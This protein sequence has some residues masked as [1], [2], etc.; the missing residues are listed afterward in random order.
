MSGTHGNFYHST[1]L[2]VALF[3]SWARRDGACERRK[4][5]WGMVVSTRS[6]SDGVELCASSILDGA[7][8]YH[9]TTPF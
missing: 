8:G 6:D 4:R 1:L 7:D 5:L 9:G 2:L 3:F